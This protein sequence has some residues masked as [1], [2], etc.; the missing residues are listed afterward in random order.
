MV[1]N[2]KAMRQAALAARRLAARSADDPLA[3]IRWLPPQEALHRC[4]A[5]RK[6]LR[7]GNQA[8]GKTTAGLA[9]LIWRCLGRHPHL[10]VQP[11]PIEAWVLCASW[12]QSL[13]IQGKLW[14]LCPKRL[15]K[16][17]QRYDP[18]NGFGAHA[19]TLIF[20]NGS[21]IRVKTTKQRALDL[22]GATID[23]AMFDEPPA[24]QRLYSEV[25]KRV[26]ARN[27]VI[28]L[29]LTP[30]NAPVD[31]LRRETEDGRIV[32]LHYRLEAR[33]LIPVGSTSPYRLVDG[34]VCDDAW[35]ARIR[36]ETL[37]HEVP[38]L[39]DGEW[40]TRV[41]GRVFRAF[42]DAGDG[43]HV[44]A[45]V[46]RSEVKLALGIDH[47]AGAGREV[48]ILVAVDERGEHPSV[49]VLDEYISTGETT[50]EQDVRAIVAMLRQHGQ[51]WS[52][53]DFIHGN[54]P[55][56]KATGRKGNLDLENAL[57]RLLALRRRADIKP[58][59]WDAKRGTESGAG[60]KP[61]SVTW[62]HRQMLRPGCF[63]VHPRCRRLIE[64]LNKW[65][66][67]DSS[68]YKDACDALRYALIP[69]WRGV[70]RRLG[71]GPQIRVA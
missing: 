42:R 36:D 58:R 37:A 38:I 40:E 70:R 12:S 24:S 51:D 69:W 4:P 53:L 65:D 25:T 45:E 9:E 10:R 17:G 15:L 20:A 50:P 21:K 44:T 29:T 52:D 13:A 23:V 5:R 48:A 43:A 16:P 66:Y 56:D 63:R 57:V 22:A 55:Y 60:S 28:L 33:H 41:E 6:L 1:A 19:P 27:G 35:I 71:A 64:S 62:L 18:V 59:I 68:E 3:H 54:R 31:W 11:P 61:Q 8:Y 7:A 49:Y 30:I 67:S 46:P 47:G 2:V 32:D 34:T 39:C 14:A 26:M